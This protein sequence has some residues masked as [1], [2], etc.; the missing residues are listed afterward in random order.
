MEE[1]IYTKEFNIN[2]YYNPDNGATLEKLAFVFRN[3]DGSMEG[4]GDGGTD[5]F[6]SIY[7]DDLPLTALLL[8]PNS[9][10]V[11]ETG[12]SITVKGAASEMA[13]LQ[14]YDN[15]TLINTIANGNVMDYSLDVST[16]G[17]HTVLFIADNG[18]MQDTAIFTYVVPSVITPSDP[19]ADTDL[20]VNYTSATGI[21]LALYAPDKEFVFVRGDFNDWALDPNYQMNKSLDG[22][23]FWLDI[24]NLDP[25]GVYAY[26]YFVDGEIT[27]ADPYS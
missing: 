27:I 25:D 19:P 7:P 13:E 24:P 6:Y 3:G 8:A 22:N 10:V 5:I 2:D 26:Q 18:T 21:R 17:S 1:D 23:T 4:K 14:L 20:G 15:G 11:A 16:G 9:A 12:S